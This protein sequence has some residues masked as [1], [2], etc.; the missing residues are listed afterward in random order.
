MTASIE[1]WFDFA[2]PYAFVALDAAEQVAARY[3]RTVRWRPIL[4]W[5]A[6]KAHGVPPPM[7]PPARRAYFLVDM[8]RSAAYF[9]RTYRAP[10][11]FPISTHRAARLYYTLAERDPALAR[12]V[13]GSLIDAYFQ[14]DQDISGAEAI[15]TVAARL[16]VPETESTA[17]KDS[18]VGRRALAQ[19]NE[20]A[21][22]AGVCGSPWFVVDGEAFFG[23][24]RLPQIEW[25]L[26][27]GEFERGGAHGRLL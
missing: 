22:A 18:E 15:A 17:A 12:A 3:G 19:A 7:D 10:R 20:A 11:H 6:L 13:G 26:G 9:G 25:G 4:L 8:A 14:D 24:D 21:V 23:A 27:G 1:M 16:G 5:A 2:S